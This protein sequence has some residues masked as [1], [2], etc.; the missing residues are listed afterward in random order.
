MFLWLIF[1]RSLLNEAQPSN[2]D[3]NKSLSRR[4][5][6]SS[7]LAYVYT[8][9]YINVSDSKSWAKMVVYYV[10][11]FLENVLLVG[12][13]IIGAGS[14]L[15]TE[16]TPPPVGYPERLK[17]VSVVIGAFAGGIVF[18]LLYYRYFHVRRLKYK[19]NGQPATDSSKIT[20]MSRGDQ[21]QK[22][23]SF[24]MNG[25]EAKQTK[26]P[27]VMNHNRLQHN[28]NGAFPS[29]NTDLM[30][31]GVFSCRLNRDLRIKRKKKKP[32]SFV[33][34]PAAVPLIQ[35]HFN[36]VQ[37][38]TPKFR[39]W[40]KTHHASGTSDQDGS[41]G[42]RVNI[43]QKLR[44]KKEQQLAELRVIEEE[45][46]QGKLQRP[47][48]G[49]GAADE[50]SFPEGQPGQLQPP[51]NKR[52]PWLVM[53]PPP[54]QPS[55]D[56]FHDH[57]LSVP[58]ASMFGGNGNDRPDPRFVFNE[59]DFQCSKRNQSVTDTIAILLS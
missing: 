16:E 59:D 34:P 32:T 46:K 19:E 31:P 11:M 18:L 9:C 58:G 45:I 12:V 55:F 20:D 54:R 28:G 39:P 40:W 15:V 1:P 5:F 29:F 17:I 56:L 2:S 22:E 33:P 23:D 43:Q 57:R 52:A 7:L 53:D 13:W 38:P 4:L 36:A 14:H 24:P 25:L 8:F 27:G 49:D 50:F 30:V 42:S 3:R 21:R 51:K 48:G 10:I 6:M 37:P 41:V 44:E 26:K 35:P 47:V